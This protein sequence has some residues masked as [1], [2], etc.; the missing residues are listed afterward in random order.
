MENIQFTPESIAAVAGFVL[1]LAFSYLPKFR[2]WYAGLQSEVKS[3]IMIG[4][5]LLT[6]VVIIVLALNGII[7]VEEPIT[8]QRAVSI[9]IALLVSNQPTY[10]LLPQTEDVKAVKA[11]RDSSVQMGTTFRA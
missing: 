4:V 2:V 10:K 7:P 5:L 11:V 3:Y 6:E 9:A 1:M 8:W